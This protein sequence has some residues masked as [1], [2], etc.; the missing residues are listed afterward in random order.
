[1]SSNETDKIKP[2][3]RSPSLTLTSRSSGL[4]LHAS[5][6]WSND[7]KSPPITQVEQ[8]NALDTTITARTAPPPGS[9]RIILMSVFLN[10]P[11]KKPYVVVTFEDKVYQTST[12]EVAEG[13]W[14]EGFEFQITY[15]A[16]LFDTIQL[17]LYDESHIL[18]PDKHVG[19]AEIRLKHLEGMPSVFT[20]YYE[21]WEKKQASSNVSVVS[22]KRNL[23]SNIGA[24]QCRIY[25]HY[26]DANIQSYDPHSPTSSNHMPTSPNAEKTRRTSVS[27]TSLAAQSTAM[28]TDQQIGDEFRKQLQLERKASDDTVHFQKYEESDGQSGP[29]NEMGADG[30]SQAAS[31]DQKSWFSNWFGS[32][33]PSTSNSSKSSL[34]D[35][36]NESTMDEESNSSML[37][38]IG[39]W[40]TS[41]ETGAVLKTISKLLSAFGQGFELSNYQI[42]TGFA[43]L[44][45]FYSDLPRERTWDVVNNLEDIDLASRFWTFAIAAYG[46]RGIHFMGK[47]NGIWA[48]GLRNQSDMLSVVNFL[49]I[50][51]E[52]MLAYEWRKSEVFRPSYFIARDRA[53]NSIVLSIRGTMSA[54]DTMTDLACEYEQ[55]R[56]GLVH[57][58]WKA[59]AQWF[60][61]EVGPSLI[62]YANVHSTSAL[63]IVGHSLGSGTAAILTIMLLD[64]LDEFRKD[65]REFE[66]KCFGYAP[67]CAMDLHLSEKYKAH[68]QSFVFADDIVSKLSYGSMLDAKA[69]LLASAEAA[70]DLGVSKIFWTTTPE[71][72]EWEQAFQNI[73]EVRKRCL[74]STDH[75]RL[76]VAGQVFQFWIDPAPGKDPIRIVIERTDAKRVSGEVIVR[77]SILL[78]HI[79]TNFD[80]AFARAREALMLDH[81]KQT[82]QGHLD[83]SMEEKAGEIH[84]DDH[85]KQSSR[86]QKMPPPKQTSIMDDVWSTL[87]RVGLAGTTHR[88]GGEGHAIDDSE[89]EA[90]TIE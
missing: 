37:E 11:I 70:Q 74:E 3:K 55:W 29:A 8:R 76:Y 18:L 48:D 15:H 12:S 38:T 51:N 10:V 84:L 13:K 26:Q 22:Q 6:K 45:K 19:R 52:D 57:S 68:I 79:P 62:A 90:K 67:T 75:P 35:T 63:Y 49:K 43:V 73:A 61:R 32:I 66:I 72:E 46:W 89:G 69:M 1:M 78:D 16:Q 44:E 33:I 64:Y 59:S 71:G 39:T 85:V 28:L 81:A 23:A 80:V 24:I 77:R 88:D 5:P 83:P 53:T 86:K 60:L 82:D 9:I 50:S 20:N 54:F 7:I 17:D 2:K 4:D 56:G 14:N 31:E 42:V 34:N 30:I 21:I 25:Y 47:G 36:S 41:K 65:N 58:G 27:S 87:A 40:A